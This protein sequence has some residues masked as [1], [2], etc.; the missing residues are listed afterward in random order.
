MGCMAEFCHAPVTRRHRSGAA[1]KRRGKKPCMGSSVCDSFVYMQK[2]TDAV[3][4]V[5]S[6]FPVVSM[7]DHA[8]PDDR[9]F[10]YCAVSWRSYEHPR[11][12]RPYVFSVFSQRRCNWG[13]QF[14][15]RLIQPSGIGNGLLA[16]GDH[17]RI[18]VY[19]LSLSWDPFRR[20]PAVSV[21]PTSIADF[22]N[23]HNIL[24]DVLEMAQFGAEYDGAYCLGYF[25]VS[26]LHCGIAWKIKSCISISRS[27]LII[28]LL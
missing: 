3:W 17:Q 27:F 15:R 24:P 13:I 16:G 18:S 14:S 21:V 8:M 28:L 22:C 5:Q 20:E 23:G 4:T 12:F 6:A 26:V 2:Q 10:I 1:W 11:G 7:C 9:I 25:I 19:N